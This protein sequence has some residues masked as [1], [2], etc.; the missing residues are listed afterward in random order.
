MLTCSGNMIA[1]SEMEK[2]SNVKVY[3][4]TDKTAAYVGDTVTYTVLVRNYG[5]A[6]ASNVTVK[7]DIDNNFKVINV[8]D[9]NSSVASNVLTWNIKTLPGFKSGKQEESIETMSFKVV[10][11]DTLNKHIALKSIAYVGGEEVWS[12]NEYPNNATYTMERNI[13]DVVSSPISVEKNLLKVDSNNTDRVVEVKICNNMNSEWLDG[14]RDNVRVSYAEYSLDNLPIYDHFKFFRFWHDAQ[15]AYINL[16]NYRMTYFVKDSLLLDGLTVRLDNFDDLEKYGWLPNGKDNI[17]EIRTLN[18]DLHCISMKLNDVLSSPAS[19]LYNY[20]DSKFAIHK[21]GFAPIFFRFHLMNNSLNVDDKNDWSYS[22]DA[23]ASSVS[24]E[25]ESLTLVSPSWANLDD[26]GYL[27]DNYSRNICGDAP[28]KFVDNILVEEFDGYTW[29]RVL[30]N[31][32][33]N[34]KVLNNVVYTDTIPSSLNFEG[35]IGDHEGVDFIAN[36]DGKNGG[37][38]VWTCDTMMVGAEK[39][40]KYQVSPAVS[41][42]INVDIKSTV[43]ANGLPDQQSKVNV[44]M[45]GVNSGVVSVNSDDTLVDVVS[46]SGVVLRKSVEKKSA[47]KGLPVGVYVVGSE[48]V[49]KTSA[50]K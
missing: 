22:Q 11:T 38:V 39:S 30:G 5:A 6:D 20:R 26:K 8:S 12:S 27:V 9:K 34:G 48:K 7:T 13:V 46:T 47:L 18:S 24:P 43:S 10:V 50:D 41:G 35:F 3:L 19:H 31:A 28:E 14:G 4:S 45:S 15:E 1:P 49:V 16:G 36:K 33:A 42:K 40:I 25:N 37:V 21:G 2:A 29:R 17:S 32:P 44:E 23:K